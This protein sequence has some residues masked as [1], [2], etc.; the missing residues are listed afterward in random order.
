MDTWTHGIGVQ[1][2]YIVHVPGQ[3]TAE[4]TSHVPSDAQQEPV[5]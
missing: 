2:P 5:G 1:T 4:V 3:L